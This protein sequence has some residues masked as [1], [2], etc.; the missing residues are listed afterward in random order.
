MRL[1]PDSWFEA[2]AKVV[3]T[4]FVAIYRPL[5][6]LIGRVSLRRKREVSKDSSSHQGGDEGRGKSPVETVRG[7]D[8]DEKGVP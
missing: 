1:F 4:P 5:A 7:T 8:D 6:R 3:G 2:T